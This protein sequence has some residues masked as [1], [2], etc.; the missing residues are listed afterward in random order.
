[1]IVALNKMDSCAYKGDRLIVVLVIDSAPGASREDG[2]LM[3]RPTSTPFLP[4]PLVWHRRLLA[5]TRWTP[6]G[7]RRTSGQIWKLRSV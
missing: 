5:A 7:T 3:D 1:M 6:A 4:S 2:L